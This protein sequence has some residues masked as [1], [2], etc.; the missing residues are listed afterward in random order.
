MRKSVARNGF[1]TPHVGACRV[2][3]GGV[4]QLEDL[5]LVHGLDLGEKYL[6]MLTT[7]ASVARKP[8]GGT[9]SPIHGGGLVLPGH[10]TFGFVLDARHVVPRRGIENVL[11]AGYFGLGE[12]GEEVVGD[13]KSIG[14]IEEAKSFFEARRIANVGEC[15][16]VFN[17]T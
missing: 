12:D 1:L 7:P 15:G 11:E 2:G 16:C 5:G 17:E 10:V 14:T 9:A 13:I 8:T 6:T 4:V 3:C